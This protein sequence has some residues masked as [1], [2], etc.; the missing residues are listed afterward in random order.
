MIEEDELDEDLLEME[1]HLGDWYETGNPPSMTQ[2][3]QLFKELSAH[4]ME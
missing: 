4:Y 2:L 1:E 3:A